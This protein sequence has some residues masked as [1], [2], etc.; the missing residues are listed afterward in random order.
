MN[1]ESLTLVGQQKI[2]RNRLAALAVASVAAV[3]GWAAQT[4]Q[5]DQWNNP[6]GGSWHLGSNWLD[7]TV[8]TA[9][10]WAYFIN[11]TMT[12]G[13]VTFTGNAV[14][15]G[16]TLTNTT[17]TTIFDVGAGNTWTQ[18]LYTIMGD[19]ASPPLQKPSLSLTSGSVSC[20]LFLIGNNNHTEAHVTITGPTSVYT[21]SSNFAVGSDSGSNSSLLVSNGGKA[22][23]SST[24]ALGVQ[25]AQNDSITVTD[26]GSKMTI[27]SN[28]NIGGGIDTA[29]EGGHHHLDILNGGEMSSGRIL[30]GVGGTL[31]AAPANTINVSGSNSK[32][33]LTSVSGVNPSVRALSLGFNNSDNTLNVSSDGQVVTT[34]GDIRVGENATSLNNLVHMTGGSITLA[35]AGNLTTAGSGLM[36][37]RRGKLWMEGGTATLPGLLANTGATSLLQLDGGVVIVTNANVSNTAP[38]ALGNGSGATAVYRMA[39]LA[40]THT[41]LDGL[42]ILS[43]GRLEGSGGVTGNVTNGGVVAPGTSPGAVNITGNYTQS[44]AGALGIE[45]AGTGP[46]QFDTLNVSATAALAGTLNVTLIGGFSP[47]AGDFFPF[48]NAGTRTGTFN[49]V[50]TPSVTGAAHWDVIYTPTGVGIQYIPEPAT[51]TTILLAGGMLMSLRHR[52]TA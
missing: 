44:S 2:W 8:P 28:F 5:A 21:A 4:V 27:A 15:Q 41:F 48:L 45:L 1:R 46:N 19:G 29:V 33:T 39:S 43:D 40:G 9:S 31:A 35:G 30:V 24:A 13:T 36:D 25:T 11:D 26:P 14:S 49:T 10:D 12:N 51:A 42:N 3:F 37:V 22:V 32:L 34:N 50:N 23:S 6:A 38:L 7:G 16:L 47:T 17:G 20:V 52:R 18:S